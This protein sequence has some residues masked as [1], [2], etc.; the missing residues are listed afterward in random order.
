METNY[1]L[2]VNHSEWQNE[3]GCADQNITEVQT[4]SRPMVALAWS[5]VALA[6]LQWLIFVVGTLGNLLVLTVLLWR[7][8]GSNKQIPY[9]TLH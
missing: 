4:I 1:V 6:S 9:Q 2:T 3:S 5:D 8:T 7:G